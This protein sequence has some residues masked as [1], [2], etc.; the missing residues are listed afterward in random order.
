MLFDGMT[1]KD[2]RQ[3]AKYVK[4]AAKVLKQIDEKE[5]EINDGRAIKEFN[6]IRPR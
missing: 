1:K 6:S 2:Q 3:Y 4:R 5:K